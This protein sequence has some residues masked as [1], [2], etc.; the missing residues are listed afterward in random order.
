ML[1]RCCAFAVLAGSLRWIAVSVCAQ[2]NPEYDAHL[3]FRGGLP[4]VNRGRRRDDAIPVAAKLLDHAHAAAAKRCLGRGR[5]RFDIAR[6]TCNKKMAAGRGC[7]RG[8]P[9]DHLLLPLL[10]ETWILASEAI[11][12]GGENGS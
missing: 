4:E 7:V 10:E 1:K 6:T 9:T 11:R 8:K 3:F 12:S 2:A 5:R